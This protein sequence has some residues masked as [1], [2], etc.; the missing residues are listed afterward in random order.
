VTATLIGWVSS[1]ILLLTILRQVYT[2]WRSEQSSGV[3]RWLFVGQLAASCGFA[4]Y[5]WL[6][7]NW[8]FLATNIMLVIAALIGEMIYL[9]NRHRAR[10]R[11]APSGK[12]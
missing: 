6:L 8:V 5:S 3:S 11:P 9:R 4:V 1:A 7:K 10:N 12:P 2:Q